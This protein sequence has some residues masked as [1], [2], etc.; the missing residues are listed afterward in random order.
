MKDAEKMTEADLEAEDLAQVV[1][2]DLNE[3]KIKEINPKVFSVLMNL[4]TGEANAAV[5]R[6]RGNGLLAWK[7]MSSAPRTS[8][9]K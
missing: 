5:R 8:T 9:K 1:D 2:E 6:C 3:D 7:R 4:T